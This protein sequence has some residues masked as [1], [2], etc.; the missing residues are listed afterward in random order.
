MQN[1]EHNYIG[2]LKESLDKK[3][4]VLDGILEQNRIQEQILHKDE[5]DFDSFNETVE[6]KEKYINELEVL[7]KGFQSVYDRVKEEL[8]NHKDIYKQDIVKLQEKIKEITEKSMDIQ[9]GE[10]RN[11]E[12]FQKK[13]VESRKNIRS[14][15]NA[16]KVAASYYQSMNKLNVVDS[17]FLIR[18]TKIFICKRKGCQQPVGILLL[19]GF[20]FELQEQHLAD[21]L[22]VTIKKQ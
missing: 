13:M 18:N 19:C 4:K 10:A 8:N 6:V 5:I 1:N 3:L 16:N 21:I 9:S 11:K 14:V 20:G 22:V 17:Q 2:I 7:D 12:V 15:K